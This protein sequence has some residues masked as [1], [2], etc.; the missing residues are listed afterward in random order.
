MKTTTNKSEQNEQ[1]QLSSPFTICA[2]CIWFQQENDVWHGQFCG[3]PSRKKKGVTD[4]VTGKVTFGGD[5]RPYA[6][7]IN[8]TGMCETFE[9]A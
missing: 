5:Q 7:D 1:P 4:F 9:A 8:T 2:K 6:R 3:H